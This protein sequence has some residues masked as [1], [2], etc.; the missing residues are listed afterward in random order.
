LE[1][2]LDKKKVFRMKD[3]Q[4]MKVRSSRESWQVCIVIIACSGRTMFL[5]LCEIILERSLEKDEF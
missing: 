5:H 2:S 4:L 3:D 1:R